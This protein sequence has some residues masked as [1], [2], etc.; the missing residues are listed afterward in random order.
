MNDIEGNNQIRDDGDR[1]EVLRLILE[2]QQSRAVTREE[3]LD[4]GESLIAF[5][6]TL[7]DEPEISESEAS[8][9]DV[10]LTRS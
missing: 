9:E 4:I 3:A 5:F 2:C 8:T 6:E 7:G 10:A 1:V